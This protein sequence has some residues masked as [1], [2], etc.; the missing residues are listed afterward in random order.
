M[1]RPRD[2]ANEK[3]REDGRYENAA[4]V[5]KV[6]VPVED[7]H[8]DKYAEKGNKRNDVVRECGN[9]VLAQGGNE[10]LEAKAPSTS[11]YGEQRPNKKLRRAGVRPVVNASGICRRVKA[12]PHSY[13]GSEN[14]HTDRQARVA[15]AGQE[16][17][18]QKHHKR[19]DN[20]E[21]HHDAQ[22][23]E[24]RERRGCTCCGK[25]RHLAHNVEDVLKEE[26]GRQCIALNLGEKVGR[27]NC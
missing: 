12:H 2:A 20:V 25:I 21:L 13:R 5:H 16:T 26:K 4:P 10:S 24:V 9:A 14:Q 15:A 19:P 1:V 27:A 3:R 23:P 8:H 22:I 11:S 18:E 17:Q 7:K 6:A